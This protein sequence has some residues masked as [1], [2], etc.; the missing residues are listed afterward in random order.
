MD[1]TYRVCV[2]CAHYIANGT[3]PERGHGVDPATVRDA[4]PEGGWAILSDPEPCF[5]WNA[6]HRCESTL[7]GDRFHAERWEIDGVPDTARAMA[8]LYNEYTG[9]ILTLSAMTR[10]GAMLAVLRYSRLAWPLRFRYWLP[11]LRTLRSGSVGSVVNVPGLGSLPL[12]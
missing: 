9:E 7:G 6:C 4:D 1:S 2:D 10:P 11:L 12:L 5:S 8:V 3:L